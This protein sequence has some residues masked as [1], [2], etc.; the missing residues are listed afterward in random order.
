MPSAILRVVKLI[1][2]CFTVCDLSFRLP[3]LLGG[4]LVSPTLSPLTTPPNENLGQFLNLLTHN[5]HQNGIFICMN[6][7]KHQPFMY[8]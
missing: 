2:V 3:N 1:T 5:I 8:R 6:N 7:H 4:P